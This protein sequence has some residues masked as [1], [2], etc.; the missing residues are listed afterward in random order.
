MRRLE[1]PRKNKMQQLFI[2]CTYSQPYTT[3]VVLQNCSLGSFDLIGHLPPHNTEAGLGRCSLFGSLLYVCMLDV[4]EMS[5][6]AGPAFWCHFLPGPLS[7]PTTLI[8]CLF[9]PLLFSPRNDTTTP[10]NFQCRPVDDDTP[11][12]SPITDGTPEPVSEQ[13]TCFSL[14]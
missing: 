6:P 13:T 5:K 7:P 2:R 12:P 8:P 11:T 4:T 1:H 14:L 9:F 10:T 3:R